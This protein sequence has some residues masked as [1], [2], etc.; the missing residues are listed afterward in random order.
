MA[1]KDYME[2][3][4]LKVYDSNGVLVPPPKNHYDLAKILP[5]KTFMISGTEIGGSE[6]TSIVKDWK[7]DWKRAW[8]RVSGAQ[9][10]NID[11]I[12]HK[13]SS[14]TRDEV[15]REIWD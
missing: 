9:I 4:I 3:G 7:E 1:L 13:G 14:M 8:K 15:E 12:G 11:R 5:G 6:L 2:K 10:G